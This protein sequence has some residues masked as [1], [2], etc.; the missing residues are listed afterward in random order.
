MEEVKR[1]Y[2]DGKRFYQVT[3]DGEVI[4]TLPSVTTI[5]GEM[6]DKSG[7]EKWKKRVGEAEAKR[8][9]QLSMNRGTIMHRQ[10]ELYKSFTGSPEEMKEQLVEVCKTDEEINEIVQKENGNLYLEEAWK[11]FDK[12]WYNQSRFFSRVD[13]VLD[14]ER[15]LWT[16]KGGEY[17]G[18]LDN[19]SLIHI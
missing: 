14:A 6:S 11:M 9:S 16:L 15:F 7:L 19:L 8:I 17:A 5:Q 2:K 18:T 1:V 10:I 12:F 4:A 13:E 3:R